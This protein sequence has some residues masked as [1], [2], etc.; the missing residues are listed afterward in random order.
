[1]KC[2]WP[3]PTAFADPNWKTDMLSNLSHFL[4]AVKRDNSQKTDG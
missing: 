3:N 4:F 2:E 1:M